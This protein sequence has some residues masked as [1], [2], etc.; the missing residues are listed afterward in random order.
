MVR[1]SQKVHISGFKL[2]GHVYA[3][4]DENEL[5]VFMRDGRSV[6]QWLGHNTR[7]RYNQQRSLRSKYV[8]VDKVRQLDEAGNPLLVPIGD[9]VTE[10]STGQARQQLPWMA[11]TPSMV[12]HH[13]VRDEQ[14]AWFAAAKRRKTLSSKG[15]RGGR[16]PRF[17]SKRGTLSF[18]CF[19]RNGTQEVLSFVKTGKRSGFVTLKGLNPTSVS[20]AEH[21]RTWQLRI[22]V[23]IPAKMV[24]T[25]FTSFQVNLSS[26]TAVF[27]GV[28]PER[29]H[30]ST[31][32]TVGVDR[33]T[34]VLLAT[35]DGKLIN[36]DEQSTAKIK[37]LEGAYKR[38]QRSMARSQIIAEREGRDFRNSRRYQKLKSD[39]RAISTRI[40]NIRSDFRHKATAQIINDHDYLALEDLKV[41]NMTRSA[42]G[43]ADKPGKNVAQKRGLNRVMAQ[44]APSTLL[45]MLKYKAKS[46]GI[47]LVEVNP[48]WTSQRCNACGHIEKKNRE[49][50]AFLCLICGHK[51]HA[52]I[53][54]AKNIL[55]LALGKWD[56]ARSNRARAQKTEVSM[57]T[58]AAPA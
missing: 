9:V 24:I 18:G 25:D 41:K 26:M 13:A 10:L 6:A 53:N 8:Y 5:P 56:G 50:Q 31:G 57:L 54:A 21:P 43:T 11:S 44:A 16:M 1:L 12:L 2:I 37:T 40:N 35:S 52:D 14:S 7:V 27:T 15:G 47:H 42:K 20:S 17:K 29:E 30:T 3:G 22:R 19:T 51:D 48:R 45:S 38:N 36:P 28:P 58:S 33:G 49:K 4:V 55:D 39:G 34:N 23:R 32:K 46:A